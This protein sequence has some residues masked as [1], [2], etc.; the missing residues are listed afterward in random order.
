MLYYIP[1]SPSLNSTY[2]LLFIHTTLLNRGYQTAVVSAYVMRALLSTPK[3][4]FFMVHHHPSTTSTRAPSSPRMRPTH[5]VD[6][7]DIYSSL[8]PPTNSLRR[9]PTE[10]CCN[11]IISSPYVLNQPP[12][13]TLLQNSVVFV[14]TTFG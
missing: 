12:L 4:P 9:S 14:T 11:D 8:G 6:T 7:Y 2:L 1:L 5:I 3:W 13:H 10:Y